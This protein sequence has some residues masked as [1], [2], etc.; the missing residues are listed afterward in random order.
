MLRRGIS[1]KAALSWAAGLLTGG[2]WR[3][4]IG[5]RAI[6]GAAISLLPGVGC[7]SGNVAPATAVPLCNGT[8]RLTLRVFFAGHLGLGREVP[9]SAVR[10]ENGFPSF[11]VDGQCRYFM[12]GGWQE[13]RQARDQGW[14]QGV[15]SDEMNRLLEDHAGVEDLM[16]TYDCGNGQAAL[17]ASPVI[18]GNMRSSVICW[19]DV[20][21]GV[22]ELLTVIRQNAR[23]LW[24]EGQPLDGD[25]RITVRE[26][27]GLEPP[28]RYPWPNG[29]ELLDFFE[30]ASNPDVQLPGKSK[31]V[32]A[33]DAEPLRAIREQFLY[34]TEPGVLYTGNGI[35]VADGELFATMFMRDALPYEDE[36]GLLPLPAESR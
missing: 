30:P 21:D 35:P 18:V 6:L 29:L 28:Q 19:S 27:V 2:E 25:L 4:R 13:D 15:V 31:R 10:I 8:P 5:G 20:S 34:D 33:M 17:D 22:R 12:S 14:R 1:A 7:S 32:A 26:E 9:G 3:T 11:A 23:E 24:S 16:G 36:S